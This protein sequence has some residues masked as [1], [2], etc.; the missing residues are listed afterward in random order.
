MIRITN[1]KVTSAKHKSKD[2]KASCKVFRD[3]NTR[4]SAWR[5]RI[6]IGAGRDVALPSCDHYMTYCARQQ[7]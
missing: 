3:K 2:G 6:V 7:M 4:S 1:R 5:W